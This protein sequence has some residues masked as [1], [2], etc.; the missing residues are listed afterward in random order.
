MD[1]SENKYIMIIDEI[2]RGNIAKIF[3]ELI[4]LIE[5][6][7]RN[8][9]SLNLAYSQ[10]K[11]TVPKNLYIIGTMNTA[12]KSLIEM[13]TALR[14]RFAFMELMPDLNLVKNTIDSI[15][16][17]K[18]LEKLNKKI[19]KKNLRDKQIGHSYFMDI[20][21]MNKLKMVFR[22]EI[23]P[24]LQEYFYEDYNELGEILGKIISKDKMSVNEELI[25]DTENFK[26]ELLKIINEES[27]STEESEPSE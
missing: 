23:I 4:T 26:K 25:D 12:D 17:K 10:K 24:L 9:L 16:L 13:D 5:A 11:F 7:K 2:N 22:F 20:S 18:L 21:D 6:D 15:S 8:K 27:E 14:R 1:D 19:R 3:G